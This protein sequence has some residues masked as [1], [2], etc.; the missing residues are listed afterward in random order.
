[1]LRATPAG[2]I[3]LRA[4]GGAIA[5][6]G[7]WFLWR[8]AARV[9]GGIVPLLLLG[10]TI[11]LML[12]RTP[13]AAALLALAGFAV[14]ALATFFLALTVAPGTIIPGLWL[15]MI[16]AGIT[17]FLPARR[18]AFA[19]L[20]LA[21]AA[22]FFLGNWT[23][24][25][26]DVGGLLLAVALAALCLPAIWVGANRFDIVLKV[27]ASWMIAIASLSLFVSL[28]AT[29]GYEPDHMD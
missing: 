15:V 2:T 19:T 10:F 11:G 26:G 22:G 25:S 29:P 16:A 4:S 3:A 5:C 6:A 12:V 13:G 9:N 14:T 7:L 20:P 24:P 17:L 27:V 1:M 8:A 23:L 18:I 28:I 21:L